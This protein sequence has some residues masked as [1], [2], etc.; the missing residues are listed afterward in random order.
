[1][2]LIWVDSG[3][4]QSDNTYIHNRYHWH[5][6]STTSPTTG[7]AGFT[8]QGNGNAWI[9]RDAAHNTRVG[10]ELS[11]GVVSLIAVYLEMSTNS[12]G[13]TSTNDIIIFRSGTDD[14][15]YV[16]FTAEN[17]LNITVSASVVASM[18]TSIVSNDWHRLEVRYSLDAGNGG[19]IELHVSGAEVLS[20]TGVTAATGIVGINRVGIRG[21]TRTGGSL[22]RSHT[23]GF[24]VWTDDAPAS[25]FGSTTRCFFYTPES[26]DSVDWVP[27]DAG[28]N[29]I[30]LDEFPN[31][32]GDTTFVSSQT[33]GDIDTYN[34]SIAYSA[35]GASDIPIGGMLHAI[36][37]GSGGADTLRL[38]FKYSG[39]QISGGTQ[40]GGLSTVSNGSV[41]AG[42][43]LVVSSDPGGG[44]LTQSS[45][46]SALI[47]IEHA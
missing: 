11:A 14:C 27:D 16:G 17:A 36:A 8:I 4:G 32:D 34:V 13:N 5:D 1:M 38:I 25:F 10:V 24:I 42:F 44:A 18:T 22:G 29:A 39:N 21:A 43:F 12:A 3:R 23:E 6:G 2:A 45:V 33:S 9:W 37:R 41:Y 26:D 19:Q 20:W 40:S 7:G 35:L 28:D 30:Q 47:G 46:T 15:G 31:V